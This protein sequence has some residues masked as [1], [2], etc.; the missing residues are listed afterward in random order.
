M[1]Y[2]KFTSNAGKP[3]EPRKELIEEVNKALEKYDKGH[4]NPEEVF[5]KVAEAIKKVT[6]ELGPKDV[7]Y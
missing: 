5:N 4:G 7:M 1:E 6:Y 3:P 2:P